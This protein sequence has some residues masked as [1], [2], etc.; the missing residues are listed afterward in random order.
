MSPH[1]KTLAHMFSCAALLALVGCN[2][3]DDAGNGGQT[4]NANGNNNSG[5]FCLDA[6]PSEAGCAQ[7]TDCAAGQ[8]CAA[9]EGCRPSI[10]TCDAATGQ[11]NCTDDCSEQR[12]CGAAPVD[13]GP[14]PTFPQSECGVF[15]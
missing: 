8:V 1:I 3:A 4:N 9:A 2:V 13:C 5:K 10:C 12:E 6:N 7:D 14:K 11:W 15:S